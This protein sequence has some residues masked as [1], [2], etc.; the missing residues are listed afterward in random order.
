MEI[1]I[2][3]MKSASGPNLARRPAANEPARLG[4]PSHGCSSSPCRA[5]VRMVPDRGG[6]PV[7]RGYG[8]WRSPAAA[9]TGARAAWQR[10]FTA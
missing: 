2:Y 10:R 8:R 1:K 6:G 7:N 9:N 5:G 4:W 3:K